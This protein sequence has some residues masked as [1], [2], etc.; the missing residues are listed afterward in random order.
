LVIRVSFRLVPAYR[1]HA[2]PVSPQQQKTRLKQRVSSSP[3][4]VLPTL[5]PSIP[6]KPSRDGLIKQL[7][8]TF[9]LAACLRETGVSQA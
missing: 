4:R 5:G 1:E 2:P 6:L 8:E 7:P 9:M 3:E